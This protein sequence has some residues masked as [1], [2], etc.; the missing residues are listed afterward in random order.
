MFCFLIPGIADLSTDFLKNFTLLI[1]S[2]SP[3]K[4]SK[5]PISPLQTLYRIP[6]RQTTLKSML[7]AILPS[8]NQNHFYPN[9]ASKINNIL[10]T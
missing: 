4:P 7:S 10:N 9:S 2:K 5:I 1:S 3:T 6:Y 8:K